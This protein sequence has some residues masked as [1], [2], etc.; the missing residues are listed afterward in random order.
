MYNDNNHLGSHLVK[1]IGLNMDNCSNHVS[2]TNKY[3]HVWYLYNSLER[4][5]TLKCTNMA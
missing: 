5:G 3:S 4:Q 1:A 2:V